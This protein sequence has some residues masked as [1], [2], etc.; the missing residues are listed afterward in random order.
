MLMRVLL[1][2]TLIACSCSTTKQIETKLYFGQFKLDG[3]IVTENEWNEFVKE[4]VIRVFPD[5]STIE[6]ASGNWYD[7]A[8]HRLIAEP[9]K[10]LTAVNRPSAKLSEQIDSLRYWYKELYKQQSVLRVDRR[11]N[12]RLF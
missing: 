8:Q 12:A 9:S 10:V 6:N 4:Y 11:V 3:G 2:C 7:T 5:G 1:L